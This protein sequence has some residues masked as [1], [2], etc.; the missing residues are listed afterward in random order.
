MSFRLRRHAAFLNKEDEMSGTVFHKIVRGEIPAERLYEDGSCI[1]IRDVNPVAPF[2]ILVLPK[3]THA[4]EMIPSKS[5]GTTAQ[6]TALGGLLMVGADI[7]RAHGYESFRTVI[8]TQ[9]DEG[10]VPY[11]HVHVIAG[12]EFT[13]PPGVGEPANVKVSV[14]ED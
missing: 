8:N 7:A 6:A 10:T 11:L 13:W 9:T 3:E 12:C 2:H 1:V 4:E 14:R 5:S